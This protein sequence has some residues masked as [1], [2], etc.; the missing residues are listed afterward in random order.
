MN[1]GRNQPKAI[2][3]AGKL[4]VPKVAQLIC[5]GVMGKGSAIKAT[6][7]KKAIL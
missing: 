5:T 1:S 7:T 6:K 3:V 4:T 2:S